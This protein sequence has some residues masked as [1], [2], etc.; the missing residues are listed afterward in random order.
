[1]NGNLGFLFVAVVFLAI[2]P[3]AAQQSAG[4]QAD[5]GPQASTTKS[6]TSTPQQQPPAGSHGQA[7]ANSQTNASKE[8]QEKKHEEQTGTSNDRI[9]Y[10][11]PNFLSV[12][13]EGTYPPLSTGEKFKVVA[14]GSFDWVEFVWIAAEAGIGQAEDSEPTYGQ[15]ATGYAKRYGSDFADTVIENFMVGAILP[16]ALHQDPRYYIM[17]K[18]GFWHRTA[19]ALSRIVITRSDSG[20]SELNFSEIFGSGAAAAISTYSYHPR[21]ERNFANVGSVWGTQ[22]GLDSVTFVFREFWPDIR[23]KLHKQS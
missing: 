9:F 6:A 15:G 1:L 2:Q 12:D 11:L 8:E 19:Y 4:S 13:K 14:R 21:S 16:S 18:G 5:S 22:V 3:A 23:R 10:A 7:P 20:K 17:G